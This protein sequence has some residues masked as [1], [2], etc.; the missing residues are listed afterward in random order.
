M[1]TEEFDGKKYW[2]ERLTAKYDVQGVGYSSLSKEYNEWLYRI[3]K[4]VFLRIIKRYKLKE[5][6]KILDIGSGTGFYIKLWEKL[7]T[8]ELIGIDITHLA[9][10]NLSDQFKAH[11][12]YQVDIG[13]SI[14][15]TLKR[16]AP[17][18][19]I[20]AMDVL[21]HITNDVKFE[22]ALYNI[23]NLLK[24][25]G[26][27][28]WSD[29]FLH[30]KEIRSQHIIHRNLSKTTEI[31]KNTGFSIIERRPM[32]VLMNEPVDSSAGQYL[33]FWKIIKRIA[34]YN[35]I[36][37]TVLG[38]IL[39]PFELILTNWWAESPTSEIMICQK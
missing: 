4:K 35:R 39:Y 29:N 24:P 5:A 6:D 1:Q 22:K 26:F 20:S 9:V 30:S 12:F 34:G 7:R 36:T 32:F 19:I 15:P 10:S 2:E 38:G 13:K 11:T 18:D 8:K 17:F 25:D 16:S 3:R 33:L 37:G 21:F 27:F 14:P 31:L 28:I 23:Y